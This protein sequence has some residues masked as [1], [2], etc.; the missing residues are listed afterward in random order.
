MSAYEWILRAYQ[1]FAAPLHRQGCQARSQI[2]VW[3]RTGGLEA[4]AMLFADRS[5]C[6]AVGFTD[7][8]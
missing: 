1:W 4:D 8:T 7:R 2:I 3:Y 5:L 6:C